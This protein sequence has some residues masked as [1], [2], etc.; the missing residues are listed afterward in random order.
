MITFT[1]LVLT[2][3]ALAVLTVL[4]I[5]IGGAAFIVT[6]A[7]WIVCGLII[8]LIVKWILEKRK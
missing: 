5:S 7:D 1:V 3:I 8:G 4:T 6:F 2:L